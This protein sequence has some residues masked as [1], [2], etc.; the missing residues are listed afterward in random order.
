MV[1]CQETKIARLARIEIRDRESEA[2]G[3][4]FKSRVEFRV[5]EIGGR[6]C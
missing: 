6:R 2:N 3:L 5:A 1:T 4:W